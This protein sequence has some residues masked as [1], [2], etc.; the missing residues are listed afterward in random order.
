MKNNYKIC[1]DE[2]MLLQY[3]KGETDSHT[4]TE[5]EK[6][7]SECEICSDL[8]D[9]LLFL[10]NEKELKNYSN[11][12]EIK[13]NEK[14][15]KSSKKIGLY[16]YR[17]IAAVILIIIASGIIFVNKNIQKN[18]KDIIE[19][20]VETK[21][22][23]VNHSEFAPKLEE[24]PSIAQNQEKKQVHNE[25]DILTKT[26]EKDKKNIKSPI[27]VKD[28]YQKRVQFGAVIDIETGV[29]KDYSILNDTFIAENTTSVNNNDHGIEEKIQLAAERENSADAVKEEVDDYKS[30]NI[31]EKISKNGVLPSV[32]IAG[33]DNKNTITNKKASF[34]GGED[35]FIKYISDNIDKS[36]LSDSLN[37]KTIIIA[38]EISANGFL[39]NPVIVN[40]YSTDVDKKILELLNNSP[41]WEPAMS[42]NTAIKSKLQFTFYL[43]K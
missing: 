9:G 13:I 31:S 14:L 30:T 7:L 25:N 19:N 27:I 20:N 42:N 1:Y 8:V 41:K 18:K 33:C 29:T 15:N 5:I 3:I 22:D 11:Q 36:F 4:S 23:Y 17:A 39:I 38:F 28:E 2:F 26:Y 16:R 21:N 24:A 43:N 37:S 35:A 34:P 40:G 32:N 6:H 10:E 12:I